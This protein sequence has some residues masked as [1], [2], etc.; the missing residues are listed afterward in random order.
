MDIAARLAHAH[1]RGILRLDVKSSNILVS[2]SGRAMLVDFGV[3][4]DDEEK[5]TSG[6]RGTLPYMAPE[7]LVPGSRSQLDG[8]TD[9]WALGVVLYEMLTK[10]R[11]FDGGKDTSHRE[12]LVHAIRTVHPKPPSQWI[13]TLDPSFDSICLR[14]L[15]KSID[16][17]YASAAQLIRKL[18]STQEALEQHAKGANVLSD[19]LP[20]LSI[21]E[22][23]TQ[24][25]R[26]FLAGG[27]F[28]LATVVT[29]MVL[30]VFGFAPPKRLGEIVRWVRDF[31]RRR[32]L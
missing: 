22:S 14:C 17:R 1:E 20:E 7:Q 9:L 13:P 31:R 27:C 2:R 10:H 18:K 32:R 24:T 15:A 26:H 30:V 4:I 16:I 28:I 6:L 19:D 12:N 8:R 3:A 11:P 25:N 23:D 29:A 5:W 21:L